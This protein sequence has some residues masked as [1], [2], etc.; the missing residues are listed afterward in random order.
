VLLASMVVHIEIIIRT[1]PAK[2]VAAK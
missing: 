2:G 1:A